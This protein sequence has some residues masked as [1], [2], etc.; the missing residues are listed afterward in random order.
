[1]SMKK[2]EFSRWRMKEFRGAEK[3]GIPWRQKCIEREM[4]VGEGYKVIEGFVIE[5]KEKSPLESEWKDCQQ[6]LIGYHYFVLTKRGKDVF[7]FQG[8]VKDG[9]YSLYEYNSEPP[10]ELLKSNL[11]YKQARKLFAKMLPEYLGISDE[12]AA[13]IITSAILW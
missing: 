2:T 8:N 7:G 10:V 3:S 12:T 6:H 11:T 4:K 9:K 1:M 5:Y 13:A